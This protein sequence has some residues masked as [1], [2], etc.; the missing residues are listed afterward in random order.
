MGKVLIIWTGFNLSTLEKHH[1]MT[2]GMEKAGQ[3][4]HSIGFSDTFQKREYFE[5]MYAQE[6]LYTYEYGSNRSLYQGGNYFTKI[7]N[8]VYMSTR[9][10][11]KLVSYVIKEKVT[12]III[13]PQPIEVTLPSIIIGKMFNI[14]IIPNIMEYYP[15]MP[16]YKRKKN[17][18]IRWSWR[19]I[20]RYSD[21]FIVIS[22]FLYEKI[23]QL[24]DKKL[25]RLPAIL[26]ESDS[27]LKVVNDVSNK[28]APLLV[29]TSSA[30][31]E[32]L[33]DFAL[34]SLSHIKEKKFEFVITGN[35]TGEI[36]SEFL[37]K[38]D[39]FGLKNKVR[40]SGFLSEDDLM[41]LQ[42]ESDALIIPLVNNERHR[43]RFP[44]KILSYMCLGK[45]VVTT[46]IGEPAAYFIDGDNILMDE[47]VTTLGFSQKVSFVLDNS[48]LAKN[49]GLRG[50][51]YVEEKFDM[52]TWG[53]NLKYFLQSI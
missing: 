11:L 15:A 12:S 21:A 52:L 16:S 29:Y 13:P 28:S 6:A 3:S 14:N 35:Y 37:T 7:L 38:I 18:L 32:E 23:D 5:K 46:H 9:F 24:V 36:K 30:G 53:H 43:A 41:S 51:K 39:R 25:M 4:A 2:Q 48:E 20:I 31:Y 50:K 10:S 34:E 42:K 8:N 1:L 27:L 22:D 49:I 40:F 33:L 17:V 47:S 45:P 19:L 26:P 44:Q